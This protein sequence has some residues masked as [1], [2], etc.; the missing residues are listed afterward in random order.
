[1]LHRNVRRQ[2]STPE[3]RQVFSV[4]VSV[5]RTCQ[6]LGMFPRAAV[7]C[8]I[9]YPDWRIFRPPDC[10]ERAERSGQAATMTPSVVA[11]AAAC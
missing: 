2:L 8:M 6:K 3:G 1:M 11:I 4:L 9:E 7:E 10:P 5:A